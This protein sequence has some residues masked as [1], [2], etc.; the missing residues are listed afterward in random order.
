MAATGNCNGLGACHSREEL[1]AFHAGRLP[2]PTMETIAAHVVACAPCAAT[3]DELESSTPLLPELRR[4]DL[5]GPLDEAD[6]QRAAALS[7]RIAAR[8]AE[9]DLGP[10]VPVRL[11]QYQVIEPLGKGGMGFVFKARHELM[12]RIV[13]LKVLRGTCLLDPEAVSRFHGEIRALARLRHPNIVAALDADREGDT[14]FLVMEYED[15]VDL[16]RLVRDEGPLPVAVACDCVRQAALGLQHAHE[17]GLVH[18]DVKPANLIRTPQ[19]QVKVLD[20]GLACV[21]GAG[22]PSAADSVTGHVLGTADYMAPEQ[23]GDSHAVDVRA[24]VYSLGCT[25]YHLL[26]GAPPFAARPDKRKAHAEA[27]VPPL[28]QHRGDIP[29][30][31]VAVLDRLLARDPA[32]RYGT[33]AAAAEALEPFA[34]GR[35]DD[36]EELLPDRPRPRS[37]FRLP[38]LAA[39]GG[40]LLAVVVWSALSRPPRR[41]GAPAGQVLDPSLRISH[42]RGNP[43]RP[44][45]DLGL[46]SWSTTCRD[47]VRV[48]V[49]LNN[50]AYCFLIAFNPDATEQPCPAD[51]AAP[52][53]QT[54]SFVYPRGNRYFNVG[55]DS[56]LQVFVLVVS[57][58]PLPGYRDWRRQACAAPWPKETAAA[59]AEG[60]WE[61]NGRWVAGVRGQEEER[62]G[63]LEALTALCRFFETSFPG[64]DAVRLLAFPVKATSSTHKRPDR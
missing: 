53:G 30:G 51:S 62:S 11:G 59:P 25:L 29:A 27:P 23:W 15:G 16:A 52:P 7:E 4:A 45:G 47:A 39:V 32:C 9:L 22:V 33:P 42:Y 48:H 37:R 20:L 40:L 38:A 34:A 8:L 10:S 6:A 19:G 35:P 2:L 28:R 13:A 1:T 56:G 49:E 24:D 21:R 41:P 14:H 17:H 36:T 31:L 5:P 61:Y 46:S 60:V 58:A 26:A 44:L 43:A 50:P 64:V 54:T 18:R 12:N 57:R 63:P 3:L 55:S